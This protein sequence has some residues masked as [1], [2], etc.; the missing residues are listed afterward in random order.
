MGMTIIYVDVMQLD[1]SNSQGS[2][3]CVHLPLHNGH[4]CHKRQVQARETY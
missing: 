4:K 1:D 2:Q 3:V